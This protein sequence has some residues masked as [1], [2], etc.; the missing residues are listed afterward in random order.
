MKHHLFN[1]LAALCSLGLH[2]QAPAIQWEK[3]LGGPGTDLAYCVRQTSDG[4]YILVGE[5]NSTGGD[6]TG[7]NGTTDFW[8]ARLDASGT[9]VWQK[10]LGGSGDDRGYAVAPTSD[11]GYIVAG[12]TN[13]TDGNVTGLKGLY[14]FW[15]VKLNSTGTITWQKCFGGNSIDEAKSVEQTSDG[16]YIVAGWTRSNNLDITVNNG[17]SDFWV[18]KLDASGSLTWQK[19]LGGSGDE[20]ASSVKQ[21]A[22]GGYIVAGETPSTNGDVSGNNGGTDYWVTKLSSAGAL[23]WQKCYGGSG[24]DKAKSIAQTTDGGYIVAGKAASTNGNITQNFGLENPWIVKISSTGS[25]EWQK[26]YGGMYYDDANG[27]Q[28]TNDGGYIFAGNVSS[29]NNDV[30]GNHGSDDM[31]VV[32]L[33]STGVLQWQKCLGGST[34]DIAYGVQQ[35]ADNGYVIA[36]KSNST[37]GDRSSSKGLND[38]WVVKLVGV[39]TPTGN[40]TGITEQQADL[41][42]EVYPNPTTTQLLLR[43]TSSLGSISLCN[44]LGQEVLRTASSDGITRIELPATLPRGVY[45][46]TLFDNRGTAMVSRKVILN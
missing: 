46:V 41:G 11:G 31:W 25:L 45:L 44:L 13:S 19:S 16:G 42:L 39:P 22:D 6:I 37:N 32:K 34:S 1:W 20:V 3:S 40:P 4:G 14:D 8:V 28:P 33:N 7:N 35:T 18:I 43:G 27:I 29:N 21:T 2:A 9:L 30:S 24:I 10:A 12:A 38:Y 36:G 17:G 5:T 15:V 26:C 23:V